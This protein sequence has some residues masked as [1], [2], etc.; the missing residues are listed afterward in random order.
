[1]QSKYY[2]EGSREAQKFGEITK[3]ENCPEEISRNGEKDA[4]ISE[5]DFGNPERNNG[6]LEQ[7][8]GNSEKSEDSGRGGADK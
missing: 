6:V 5:G 3:F 7:G 1:V 2:Q 8:S 4:E